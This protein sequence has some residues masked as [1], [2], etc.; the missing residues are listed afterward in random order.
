MSLKRVSKS[1]WAFVAP[2]CA[3]ERQL[4]L[5]DAQDMRA[6]REEEIARVELLYLVADCHGFMEAHN[7]LG[8]LALEANDVKLARGHFG[9][10]YENGLK[11]LPPG[12]RGLLPADEGYNG[13][14]FEAGRG[15]ARCLIALGE[16]AQGAA[17]LKKLASLDPVEPET[18]S[19]LAQLREYEAELKAG[20]G[21][22][23]ANSLPIITGITPLSPADLDD[24]AEDDDDD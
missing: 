22:T 9:Y 3:C 12:F 17:I 21:T 7:L 24:D 14:F 11:T 23:A 2:D 8:E 4:D 20:T 10:C 5:E 6:K 16:V 18:Q 1:T 13:P 19:L 15:L